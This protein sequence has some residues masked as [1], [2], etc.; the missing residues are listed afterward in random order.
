MSQQLIRPL[1][2]QEFRSRL[3]ARGVYEQ[4][5]PSHAGTRTFVRPRV[6]GDLWSGAYYTVIYKGEDIEVAPPTIEAVLWSFG[7]SI[8]AWLRSK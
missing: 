5:C 6:G 8:E 2:F 7:I 4:P 3:E 1:R